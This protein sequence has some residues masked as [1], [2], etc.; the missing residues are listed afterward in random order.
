LL[1]T[2]SFSAIASPAA[3]APS[4]AQAGGIRQVNFRD[5]G[6]QRRE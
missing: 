4:L 1:P 3:M 2:I 6:E 5:G